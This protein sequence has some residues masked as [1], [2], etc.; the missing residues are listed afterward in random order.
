MIAAPPE[1]TTYPPIASADDVH[2]GFWY[3][4]TEDANTDFVS[5]AEL[6]DAQNALCITSPRRAEGWEVLL[7][8]TDERVVMQ[9]EDLV[10]KYQLR[11][12]PWG[13]VPPSLGSEEFIRSK[14]FDDTSKTWVAYN[15][16]WAGYV[17]H[18]L[19]YSAT[20]V[21]FTEQSVDRLIR[22]GLSA[23]DRMAQH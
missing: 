18:T 16:T 2:W 20:Q 12:M 13:A 21:K 17:P 7:G 6:R 23:A 9:L 15:Q 8:A 11:R 19:Q 14:S 10:G 1:P 3:V 22:P 4:S 5:T